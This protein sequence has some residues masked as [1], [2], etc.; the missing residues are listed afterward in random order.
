MTGGRVYRITWLPGSDRLRGYC[1]CGE[2]QEAEDPI[3]LWQW[4]LEHPDR[5][6]DGG[7]GPPRS[8][9]PRLASTSA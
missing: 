2:P 9:A 3:E 5:H 1:W 4:L 8:T 6:G 7:G